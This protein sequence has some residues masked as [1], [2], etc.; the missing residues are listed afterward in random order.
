MARRFDMLIIDETFVD[1]MVTSM[2]PLELEW[3]IL[4]NAG[5][6]WATILGEWMRDGGFGNMRI[7][8]K[9]DT[10]ESIRA[11]FERKGLDYGRLRTFVEAYNNQVLL[12]PLSGIKRFVP[13][14]DCRI[15]VLTDATLPVEKLQIYLN[16]P[17][18]V[19][20]AGTVLDVTDYH[21]ENKVIGVL[22]SS[23][24]KSRMAK[25]ERF[26][27]VL[28]YVGLRCS[29]L[30]KDDRIVITTYKS[31]IGEAGQPN[32]IENPIQETIEYL[33]SKFPDLD[34][35]EEG[36]DCRIIVSGMRV[37]TNAFADFTVQFILASVHLSA[38]SILIDE[39]HT[40]I[41]INHFRRIE[42]VPEI[43][44]IYPKEAFAG[45]KCNIEVEFIPIVRTE[46]EGIMEYEKYR[47]P[48][49]LR[50]SHKLAHR[51]AVGKSQQ[52][53]RIRY[54]EGMPIRKIVETFSNLPLEGLM[55]TEVKLFDQCLAEIGG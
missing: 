1:G 42:G 53:D 11:E 38:A 8:P 12:S 9:V 3:Q 18:T 2:K 20:G 15:L 49:P 50:D 37:G 52:I 14:A 25:E 31:P 30:Y 47:I 44:N 40:N 4:L 5:E 48:V 55:F 45:E 32:Y 28:N 10:L 13:V 17:I 51:G 26:Y 16:R 33:R 21:P 22:D 24:S 7:Y 54:W 36:T 39:Y 27:E 29:S 41:A 23:A 34:I 43:L 6:D 35:G 46:K 19:F